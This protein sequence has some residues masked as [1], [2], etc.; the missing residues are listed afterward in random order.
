MARVRV[1][2]ITRGVR[3]LLK[4]PETAEEMLRR[5]RKVA[6]QAKANAP[7][8]SGTYRASIYAETHQGPSRV[9][10]RAGAGVAYSDQI[11]ARHRVL[12]RA[13]DAARGN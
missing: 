10:G 13:I 5:A 11:E 2:L 8:V 6:D 7:V 9:T 3:E 4:S 12:G 1:K